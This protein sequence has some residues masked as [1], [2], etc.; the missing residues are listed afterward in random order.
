MNLCF[1][2]IPF[3]INF[4]GLHGGHILI[5]FD[6]EQSGSPFPERRRLTDIAI[7]IIKLRHSDTLWFI[8]NK[9]PYTKKTVSSQWMGDLV[10]NTY[11]QTQR[12]PSSSMRMYNTWSMTINIMFVSDTQCDEF[13]E[14]HG[15][16]LIWCPGMNSSANY[17]EMEVSDQVK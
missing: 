11:Y 8:Y 3:N 4:N 12:W 6:D 13:T 5:R 16:F 10:P 7:L 2:S 14:Q 1:G 9:N 17:A 15:L